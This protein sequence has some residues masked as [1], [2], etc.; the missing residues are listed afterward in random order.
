MNEEEFFAA[1]RKFFTEDWI[2]VGGE[3]GE[4]YKGGKM[5]LHE[6]ARE[7]AYSRE[8]IRKALLEQYPIYGALKNYTGGETM[9]LIQL[10][11]YGAT[12]MPDGRNQYARIQAELAGLERGITNLAS[13]ISSGGDLDV[14]QILEQ[15]R[16][17]AHE[18]AREALPDEVVVPLD[19][20]N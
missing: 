4:K 18:A 17:A 7:G 10:A 3:L 2:S 19:K 6:L 16:E 12:A 15:I 8:E 5:S 11:R 13:A 14:D 20:E 9:N 1:M